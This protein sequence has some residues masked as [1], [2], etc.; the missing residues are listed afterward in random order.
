MASS[1][2]RRGP[3]ADTRTRVTHRQA[4]ATVPAVRPDRYLELIEQD[5]ARLSAC[6]RRA[7]LDA[8]I[9]TC[10]GWT[11]RDCVTHTAWV[12]QHKTACV[13]L[14]RRPTDDEFEQAPPPGVDL[15]DWFDGSLAALVAE[16]RARGPEAPAY[17]WWPPD[18]TAGF[19]YRR[20]AQETAVHRLDVEDGLGDPTPVD[21]ELAIDGIDEVLDRFL[22]EEWDDLPADEWGDVDPRA[23]AGSTVAVRSGGQVWRTTIEPDRM[24]LARDDGPAEA[25][26]EGEPEAVLVWLWGRRPDDAVT[27]AGD[28]AVL[29]AFRDRLRIATQVSPQARR[30]AGVQPPGSGRAGAAGRRAQV[31]SDR[32]STK[33]RRHAKSSFGASVPVSAVAVVEAPGASPDTVAWPMAMSVMPVSN[34]ISMT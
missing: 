2:R 18:Q 34:A 23:G 14:A 25:T 5:G 8:P 30:A 19:W 20:M 32:R 9:P 11:V 33:T 4:G 24:P 6:A 17:S 10:P 3:A 7:D 22:A 26:V 13:R 21:S 29:S 28:A 27:L 16:L 31:S 12:Y 15:V 1:V